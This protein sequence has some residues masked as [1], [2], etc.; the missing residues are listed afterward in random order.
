MTVDPAIKIIDASTRTAAVQITGNAKANTIT[1][2]SD[3][4]TIYG[5]KGNDSISGDMLK[6]LK[7]NG[8]TGS[9]SKSKYSG[10]T[11]SLTIA[12]GRQV[13]FDNVAKGDTFNINNTSYKISGSKLVKT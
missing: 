3:K 9:F 2:G 4:D 6:I 12:G 10:G 1:G 5:G 13:I 7:S 8:K 11:L